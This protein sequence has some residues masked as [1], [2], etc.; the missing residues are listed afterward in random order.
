MMQLLEQYVTSLGAL[1]WG[2]P[3]VIF[4]I[5]TSLILTVALGFVQFRY[6]FA[7]WR[8]VFTPEKKATDTLYITPFQAFIN[9]L[10][11]SIGNG[12]A[13]G[14][15]TAVFY[16]G[17]GVG[18]WIFVLGFFL[19][20]IR[21][22]E[23]FASTLF[24]ETSSAGVT[25]GGPMV[26][27]KKVPGGSVLPG[28]YAFFCLLSSLFAGDAMQCNSITL[29]VQRVIALD[30]RLIAAALFAFA[31]YLML[32]G[33]KR[34]MYAAEAIIPVKV[35]LFFITTAIVLIFHYHAIIPAFMLMVK[36]AFTP[37][38][39][40]GLGLGFTV[41]GAIRWGMSNSMNATEVGLGTAAVL[42]GSTGS[43]HPMRTG[44]MS[45]TSAFIS[46][47]LVC[48]VLVL[49]LVASGVWDSGLNSINMTQ[50][51]YETVFHTL[52]TW[53]V[54]FLSITFGMGVL[55]AYTFIGHEC[56]NYFTGGRW[57]NLFIAIFC[58]MAVFGSLA[59]VRLVWETINIIN[60]GLLTVN[61]YGLLY[62]MPQLRAAMQRSSVD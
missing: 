27:L 31:A 49:V 6:F 37:Q 29:G 16:G 32:G 1:L 11:A 3:L 5:A 14:M 21:F 17:P 23:V 55:V 61:L 51:A 4:V 58:L 38:A 26:Y 19:L 30:A 34:I 60:A 40:A 10:S 43:K 2:W 62:L 36:S 41:Q 56:W 59:Q 44:I 22:A 8:Y 57:S 35:G 7:S 47:H 53:V 39:L 45:M 18:F 12:S 15:A 9:A 20:V 54:A 48:F 28:I 33:V 25:R 13:A 42:F 24:L 52:G 50:A 46:N